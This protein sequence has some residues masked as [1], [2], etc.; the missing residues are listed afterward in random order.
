MLLPQILLSLCYSTL[1]STPA[2]YLTPISLPLN[3]YIHL[4]PP[5]QIPYSSLLTL[6]F[7]PLNPYI[8]PLNPHIPPTQPLYS[9]PT[10]P[11]SPPTHPLYP[12]TQ[13]P[14]SP[15]STPIFPPLNPYLPPLI[16]CIRLLRSHIPP[17]QPLYS[18]HSTAISHSLL[19]IMLVREPSKRSTLDEILMHP[20]VRS[21]TR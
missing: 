8:S 16:P 3:H 12:P 19:R 21:T 9:P 2:P 15:R 11:L 6:I 7:P 13:I 14:Y 10:Q 17:A 4:Y 20:W 18:P 5:T 1:I